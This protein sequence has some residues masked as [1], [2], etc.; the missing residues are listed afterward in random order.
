MATSMKQRLNSIHFTQDAAARDDND[1]LAWAFR[2]AGRRLGTR[3]SEGV[4]AMGDSSGTTALPAPT[5]LM[6][7]IACFAAARVVAAP[8]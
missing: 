8:Q 5:A 6:L 2:S 4:D 7:A 1:Q 3:E